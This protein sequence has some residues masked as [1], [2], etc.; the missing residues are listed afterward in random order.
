MLQAVSVK[1]SVECPHCGNQMKASKENVGKRAR[2][3]QCDTMLTV[4][5]DSLRMVSAVPCRTS[6]SASKPATSK[7]SRKI[8]GLIGLIAII[9]ILTPIFLNG[10]FSTFDLQDATPDKIKVRVAAKNLK[11]QKP[12]IFDNKLEDGAIDTS[13]DTLK[14]EYR[15]VLAGD[16]KYGGKRV[17]VSGIMS[18]S[19]TLGG[20]AA[21]TLVDPNTEEHILVYSPYV[22]SYNLGRD[23]DGLI[24]SVAATCTS[25]DTHSSALSLTNAIIL[26]PESEIERLV[27][28]KKNAQEAAAEADIVDDEAEVS[29]GP[30]TVYSGSQ[31]VLYKH[32][33]YVYGKSQQMNVIF[34]FTGVCKQ[35]AIS[36]ESINVMLENE[37]GVVAK[38]RFRN[39][40]RA[41]LEGLSVDSTISVHGRA[42]RCW[43]RSIELSSCVIVDK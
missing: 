6:S 9:G 8:W 23:M 13:I 29:A 4:V 10:D 37:S 24:I 11:P 27:R 15:N 39:R 14:Q 41:K 33:K 26:T 31:E 40:H 28:E 34:S 43:R 21:F 18:Y 38:C 30:A 1:V 22:H 3:K 25:P 17:I 36:R 19:Y 42:Y 7:K 35:V 16:K 32:P 12:A 20:T 5:E 2:C